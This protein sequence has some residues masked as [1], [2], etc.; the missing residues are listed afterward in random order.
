MARI[1]VVDDAAFM[2]AMLKDIL[3]G[4]GHEIAGEGTTGIEAVAV[5]KQ[6]KP[7]LVT[8]DITMPDADGIYAL[9]EIRAFDSAAKV[10]MCS[11][12]GQKAM[13]VDA[14]RNGALDFMVKPLQKERVVEAI[15]K[16]LKS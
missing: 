9:K 10:I 4:M 12:M 14:I 7:D 1:M 6:C 16:H 11:A 15:E 13:V 3:I 2:R 5:Y 8:M